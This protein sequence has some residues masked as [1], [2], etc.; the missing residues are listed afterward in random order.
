MDLRFVPAGGSVTVRGLEFRSFDPLYYSAQLVDNDGVVV[1]EDL[2][3]SED[4]G[5][6]AGPLAASPL[7]I[8]TSRKVHLVGLELRG[9]DAT[10]VS[11]AG[12]ALRLLDSDVALHACTLRGATAW[13]ATR[14][15]RRPTVPTRSDLEEGTRC[16]SAATSPAATAERRGS[17]GRRAARPGRAERDRVDRRRPR[18]AVEV[19]G[20]SFSRRDCAGDRV[21]PREDDGEQA[22]RR[23]VRHVRSE[24]VR[25]RAEVAALANFGAPFEVRVEGPA[26]ATV[27]ATLDLVPRYVSFPALAGVLAT[28]PSVGI[29]PFGTTDVNGDLVVASTI[30]RWGCR[31]SAS[32]PDRDAR[33]RERHGRALEPERADRRRSLTPVR[34]SRTSRARAA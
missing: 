11:N 6:H 5:V 20:G 12:P 26:N 18:R 14:R 22:V 2:V 29:V 31:R 10:N 17:T 25:P 28:D 8:F 27:L 33:L 30:P 3:L 9:P 1:L 21:L 24:R 19:F 4:A 23:D 34:S 16:C 32:G 7:A 13:R 15:M